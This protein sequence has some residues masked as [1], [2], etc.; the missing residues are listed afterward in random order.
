MTAALL[1]WALQWMIIAPV[2]KLSRNVTQFAE[3]PEDRDRIIQLTGRGDEI[4]LT[5]Q[6]LAHMESRLAEELRKKRRLAE[7]GLAVSKINHELRN[8]LT[9]AQLLTDRLE[10]IAD[11]V[12]QR[13][14]PRLMR[15]LDRAISFCEA[16]LAYGRAQEKEPQREVFAVHELIQDIEETAHFTPQDNIRMIYTI[17]QQVMI[18]ADREQLTRVLINLVRNARQA[19]LSSETETAKFIEIS[20]QETDNATLIRVS[21]NG[22]GVPEPLR[23]KLF[24]P[25]Q[26]DSALKGG[27]FNGTG[28]GLVIAEELI[29][30]H[31]GHLALTESK[32]GA[33]F[34]I[35]VPKQHKS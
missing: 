25:F 21:D 9:T 19:H 32:Q 28:L 6:A 20:A 11:D 14:A 26:S 1:Y 12:V 8:I 22:P 33:T 7:L 17:P 18:D 23:A 3:Q 13:I 34:E 24:Q 5:E 35:W 16:T 30:A 4:G 2:V 27:G 31:G 29:S 15:V 10:G